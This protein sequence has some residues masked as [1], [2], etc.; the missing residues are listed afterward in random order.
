MEIVMKKFRIGIIGT[1]NWHAKQFTEFFNKPDVNGNF[2]F[3]SCRV[4][5][6]WGMYPDENEKVVTDKNGDTEYYECRKL[7]NRTIGEPADT[8]HQHSDERCHEK[9]GR[10]V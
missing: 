8:R 4:T 2:A 5:S 3:P 1:E 10:G 7:H 9:C 6:V